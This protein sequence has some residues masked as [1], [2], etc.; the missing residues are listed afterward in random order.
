ML[1]IQQNMYEKSII[2]VSKSDLA[3]LAGA[4]VVVDSENTTKHT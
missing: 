1:A 2:I 4:S 3:D